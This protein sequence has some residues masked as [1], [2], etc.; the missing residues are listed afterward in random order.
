MLNVAM[1]LNFSPSSLF[2]FLVI[3]VLQNDVDKTEHNV[4][5]LLRGLLTY[6]FIF[7]GHPT[8]RFGEYLSE[9]PIIAYYVRIKVWWKLE[10]SF[11]QSFETWE[12]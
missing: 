1:H 6:N 3:F 5:T 7:Q 12:K 2:H 8:D 9:R 11:P 4:N 10:F